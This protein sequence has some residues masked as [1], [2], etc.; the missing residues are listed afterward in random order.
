VK[1]ANA[2]RRREAGAKRGVEDPGRVLAMKGARGWA[3]LAGIGLLIVGIWQVMLLSRAPGNGADPSDWMK[4]I[5]EETMFGKSWGARIA[6][7]LLAIAPL[8]AFVER[9]KG[10][11]A[12]AARGFFIAW[13]PL[14]F[15]VALMQTQPVERLRS[16]YEAQ[17][18]ARETT[19]SPTEGTEGVP[20]PAEPQQPA[21]EMLPAVHVGTTLWMSVVAPTTRVA[22]LLGVFLFSFLAAT[23]H[24]KA[25]IPSVLVLLILFVVIAFFWSPITDAV[26]LI[27]EGLTLG[28]LAFAMPQESDRFGLLRH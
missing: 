21:V 7:L 9:A 15:L 22:A 4:F 8:Y 6:V 27:L 5:Q 10:G 17:T 19:P 18:T 23:V 20:V 2:V 16:L 13:I 26:V 1:R 25:R 28:V 12:V 24:R 3:L 14:A 11:F